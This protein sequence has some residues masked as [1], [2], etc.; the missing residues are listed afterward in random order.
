MKSCYLL[1]VLCLSATFFFSC[2]Q[3]KVNQAESIEDSTA[4]GAD[5]CY[6]FETDD[7]YTA[8]AYL[9]EDGVCKRTD[10]FMGG[11]PYVVAALDE[12]GES[13]PNFVK[14]LYDGK[15]NLN[16]FIQFSFSDYFY[17]CDTREGNEEFCR[18]YDIEEST[19]SVDWQ[20]IMFDMIKNKNNDETYFIRY[21]FKRDSLDRIIKVYDPIFFNSIASDLD[22]YIVYEV[23][24]SKDFWKNST[25]LE[26]SKID[27]IFYE[28]LEFGGKQYIVRKFYGYVDARDYED[29]E[30]NADDPS[31]PEYIPKK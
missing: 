7:G 12:D 14:Y 20:K 31:Y 24:E 8:K 22:N 21:Y 3:E 1:L 30:K 4:V 15:G 19:D 16:G 25:D 2:N 5:S 13:G 11:Q 9:N 18:Q 26:Q 28:I 10:L 6:E 27:L 29:D 17:N 23:C